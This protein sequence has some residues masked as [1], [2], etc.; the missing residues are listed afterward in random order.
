MAIC[1]SFT[2]I[3]TSKQLRFRHLNA[4]GM[5]G[6]KSF[7]CLLESPWIFPGAPLK[8]NGA[9][10]GVRGGLT[11]MHLKCWHYQMMGGKLSIAGGG[12][13]P[14]WWIG[15]RCWHCGLSWWQPV[16]PPVVAGLSDVLL[17]V[18]V[19][20]NMFFLYVYFVSGCNKAFIYLIYLILSFACFPADFESR[21]DNWV[22]YI[23]SI[24]VI[25]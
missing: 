25:K 22:K 3:M 21:R 24:I 5:V 13:S 20:L 12:G 14:V 7:A 6:D 18:M 15:H 16:V 11:G 8:I 9:P 1:P 10:C 23:S 2:N 19:I 17:S 4:L